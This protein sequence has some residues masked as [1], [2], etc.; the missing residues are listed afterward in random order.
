MGFP[1]SFKTEFSSSVCTGEKWP[2]RKQA[3][4][5]G[6]TYPVSYQQSCKVPVTCKPI[7]KSWLAFPSKQV[8]PQQICTGAV[9]KKAAIS[10]STVVRVVYYNLQWLREHLDIR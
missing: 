9:K 8:C 6:Q 4:F 10:V 3:D 1:A 5:L 7:A 2:P